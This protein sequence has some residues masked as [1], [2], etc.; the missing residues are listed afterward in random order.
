MIKLLLE[1]KG[2]TYKGTRHCAAGPT[3]SGPDQEALKRA[4][5]R[6]LPVAWQ[7]L[8]EGPTSQSYYGPSTTRP[9][10][11]VVRSTPPRSTTSRGNTF[12]PLEEMAELLDDY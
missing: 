3:L 7:A 6:A 5:Q 9:S 1:K 4:F 8:P 10:R 12:L 11:S 2:N